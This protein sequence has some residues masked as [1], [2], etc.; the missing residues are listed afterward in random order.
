VSALEVERG[1]LQQL[2]GDLE[3]TLARVR[4]EFSVHCMPMYLAGSSLM[5]VYELV[6]AVIL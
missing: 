1:K 5:N 4:Y 6:Q 2:I 3:S